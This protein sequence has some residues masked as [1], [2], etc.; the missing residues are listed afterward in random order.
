[1]KLN[2]KKISAHL[3][4][5]V[6]HYDTSLYGF[7]TPVLKELFFPNVDPITALI[8]IV[9]GY[10]VSLF[11]KPFGALFFGYLGDKYGR[12]KALFLSVCGM[13]LISVAMGLLPTYETI[14]IFAPVLLILC[15]AMQAFFVAGEYNGGAIYIIEHDKTKSIGLAS[16]IYCSF[17]A[18][19]I[20]F[21]SFATN[22]VLH[23][24]KEYWRYAYLLSS[25]TIVVC[26]YFRVVAAETPE[27]L[28]SSNKSFKEK[29]FNISNFSS[30][31]L[32]IA[33][34]TFG[35]ALYMIP[36]VMVN[37]FI[38]VIGTITI[39]DV[40][41]V[42]TITLFIYVILLP[43]AGY[44]SDK[45]GIKNI[46]LSSIIGAIF[47]AVPAFGILGVDN[48]YALFVFK[49]IMVALNALFFASFHPYSITSFPVRQRYTNVSFAYSVGSQL[50]AYAPAISL[51][52]YNTTGLIYTHSL[53]IMV[54]ALLTLILFKN[55]ERS[56]F[57]FQYQ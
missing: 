35:S 39:K 23:Y 46:L 28:N 14:G 40:M 21:A 12:K 5:L 8:Y 38:T 43:F 7:L 25:L 34:S 32:I 44:L 37:S 22:L 26:M 11:F 49:C 54:V 24:G 17:T 6:E 3:G 53:L 9:S 15:R 27:F 47:L 57:R 36:T 16:G 48:I 41:F 4:V 33:L 52:I 10:G 20:M 55:Y 2:H 30:I 51:A 50:G 13:A 19:G 56:K 18:L 29:H 1:M 31:G 45:I 42:N